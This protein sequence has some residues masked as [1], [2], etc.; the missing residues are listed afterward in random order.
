MCMLPILPGMGLA[1]RTR[2]RGEMEDLIMLSHP[3]MRLWELTVPL[4]VLMGQPGTV[5]TLAVVVAGLP[6]LKDI[7]T[8]TIHLRIVITLER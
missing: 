2:V 8:M 4:R 1:H 5:T 3:V 6:E 7:V